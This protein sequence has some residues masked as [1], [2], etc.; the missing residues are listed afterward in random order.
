VAQLYR[1]TWV[2]MRIDLPLLGTITYPVRKFFKRKSILA[3]WASSMFSRLPASAASAT[4]VGALDQEPFGDLPY[5]Q[6]RRMKASRRVDIIDDEA[7]VRDALTLLLSTAQIEPRSYGSAEEYLTSNPLNEPACVL[8]DNQLPG[9][10]GIWAD[11]APTG[12]ALGTTAVRAIAVIPLRARNNPY[13]PDGPIHMLPSCGRPPG[14]DWD[15]R[16]GRRPRA[17]GRVPDGRGRDFEEPVR[18]T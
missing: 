7:E 9:M 10:S 16:E 15:R 1:F 13:R 6:T 3:N 14:D 5:R 18:R 2:E 12:A 4:L 8:L 11:S 17:H